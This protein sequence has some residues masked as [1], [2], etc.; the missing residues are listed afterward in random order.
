M[1]RAG[2]AD[3]EQAGGE[4]V[5]AEDERG[6]AGGA[7]LLRIR[8]GEECTFAG[9]AIDVGRLVAHDAVVVSADVVHADVV[10]QI[11]RMFGL[12]AASSEVLLS[13]ARQLLSACWC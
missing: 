8:V 13:A 1:V 5:L 6:T 9:E 11:T 2:H 10:T 12:S 3:G 4:W 7:A